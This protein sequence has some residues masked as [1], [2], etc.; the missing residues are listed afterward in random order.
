MAPEAAPWITAGM[1]L[2]FAVACFIWDWWD[3]RGE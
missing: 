3:N 1:F 2:L